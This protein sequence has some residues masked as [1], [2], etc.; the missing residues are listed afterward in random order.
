MSDR[1]IALSAIASDDGNI[2]LAGARY[3]SLHALPED[4]PILKRMRKVETIGW[5]RRALDRAIS[6][7]EQVPVTS[8]EQSA[9]TD[10][11]A[12]LVPTDRLK[13]ELRAEAIE[14][15]TNTILHEFAPIVGALR[16]EVAS[17]MP[18]HE[19]TKT[20]KLL[21]R[22][23]EVM[24]AVRTL[25][26]AAS[27]PNYSEFDLASLVSE[28]RDTLPIGHEGIQIRIA[29]P[30]PFLVEADRDQMSLVITNGL[31]NA[32]EAVREHSFRDPP[33]LVLNW[34]RA[35]Y[36]NWL[37]L[38][39]TGPGFSG[40]PGAALKLGNTNK[41]DH[42]GYGLAMALQA[43]HSMEGVVQLSNNADGGAKFELR[44]FGDHENSTS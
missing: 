15:V 19:G 42:I 44:W 7:L 13:R 22:L 28:L 33:E 20:F 10:D 41:E 29:G 30:R 17:E 8:N 40:D 16:L 24:S 2:R 37:V 32:I 21:N 34:G 1:D 38:M 6:R 43:M 14:D 11:E 23:T 9:A 4:L 39:D 26:K 3:F 35:G 12:P 36:E 25:K 5:I 27:V 18:N 31:K